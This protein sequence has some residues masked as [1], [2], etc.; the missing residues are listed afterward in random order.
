MVV[1]NMQKLWLAFK[2]IIIVVYKI[3]RGKPSV[4]FKGNV[5]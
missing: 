4:A 5:Y 1:F 3:C 2:F